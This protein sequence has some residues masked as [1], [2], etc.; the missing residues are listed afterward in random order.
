MTKIE[1]KQMYK[2][3]TTMMNNSY[4]RKDMDAYDE[5]S[6]KRFYCEKRIYDTK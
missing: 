1:T 6:E 3:F 4:K 2:Y 5:F